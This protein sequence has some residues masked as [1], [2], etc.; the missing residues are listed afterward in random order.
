[1]SSSRKFIRSTSN[2]V[3]G[4]HLAQQ[5]DQPGMN[6]RERL[7]FEKQK[8]K[9]MERDDMQEAPNAE[10]IHDFNRNNGESPRSIATLHSLLLPAGAPPFPNVFMSHTS[11]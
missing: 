3:A 4:Q 1:M 8:L 2:G 7:G 11:W 10:C 5:E 9:Q 6:L